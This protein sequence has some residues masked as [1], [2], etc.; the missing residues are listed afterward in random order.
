ML[1]LLIATSSMTWPPLIPFLIFLTVMAA[2][3]SLQ[4]RVLQRSKHVA[5]VSVPPSQD[6]SRWIHQGFTSRA[7]ITVVRN[8]AI[9]AVTEVCGNRVDVAEHEVTGTVGML[10]TNIA[11][12]S[13]YYVVV[14]ITPNGS[15]CHIEIAARPRTFSWGDTERQARIYIDKVTA[16]LIRLLGGEPVLDELGNP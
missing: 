9:D 13:Q 12:L 1:F 3:L 8:A 7:N 2:L 4:F 11:R 16:E 6:R 10:M 5:G 15:G 14:T